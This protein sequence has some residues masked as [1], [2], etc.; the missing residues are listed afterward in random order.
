MPI[1]M[2]NAN[3]FSTSRRTT[4]AA[5]QT[6]TVVQNKK[7]GNQPATIETLAR[8]PRIGVRVRTRATAAVTATATTAGIQRRRDGPDTGAV[9]VSVCVLV[10]GYPALSAQRVGVDRSHSRPNGSRSPWRDSLV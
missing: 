4:P 1:G 10:M 3:S 5:T 8:L 9:L 2:P 6:A 7:T